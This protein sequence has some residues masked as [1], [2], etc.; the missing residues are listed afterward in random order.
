MSKISREDAWNKIFET[1]PILEDV[2][3]QGFY[4][5]SA[6]EISKL[7]EP[8]LM[9]KVDYREN[10]PEAMKA[11]GLSILA[12]NN[13]TYRIARNSPFVDLNEL[14]S[15]N[16]E[17]VNFPSGFISLDPQVIT[18]E[19][20]ALDVA[21][22]SGMLDQ[23]F[24]EETYLSIR[25]RR[26]CSLNFK[27]GNIEYP[28]NGV[29]VE[30]DGGYEGSTTVNLVEAKIGGRNNINIRQLLYPQLYWQGLKNN[31]KK[32][33]S[34]VF[35]YQ[36]GL[37]RFIP[38]EY[39]GA[40][41]FI[42]HSLER[43]FKIAESE[44]H[45]DLMGISLNPN[46]TDLEVPFPQ[47]DDFDKVVAMLIIIG[48]KNRC[49]K[50]E[51]GLEFDLVPRQIDYYSNVLRWMKLVIIESDTKF[52]TLT[53]LGKRLLGMQHSQRMI[54]L[55]RIIFSNEIFYKKLRNSDSEIS[56][57]LR[58]KHRLDNQ[59]LYTRRMATVKSWIGYFGKYFET[60]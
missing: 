24:G 30:V 43:V 20:A 26:Y 57:T 32:T 50:D 49:S 21:K 10:L 7:K 35:Q 6:E 42:N 58:N 54:E 9:C 44:T 2:S 48:Q 1:N 37:Y 15:S 53:D 46:L 60:N 12:I 59:S 27:I 39:W 4:D 31:H 41:C 11:E 22:I 40:E 19:S 45:F 16:I 38:F 33:S 28:V 3:R 55:A 23:V 47:A 34:Y 25:G 51:I 17:L 8:R 18:S 52:L 5:I 13:G 56:V 36:N 29:Q 14:I